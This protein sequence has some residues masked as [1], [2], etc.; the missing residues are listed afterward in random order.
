MTPTYEALSESLAAIGKDHA[1]IL[2]V[3]AGVDY[4]ES[5]TILVA[6]DAR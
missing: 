2:V 3:Q 1:D 6:S 4:P 5:A